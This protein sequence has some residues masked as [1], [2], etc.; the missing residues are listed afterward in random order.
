MLPMD[1]R[2]EVG[3]KGEQQAVEYLKKIGY[4]ILERNWRHH[5]GELDVVA[6][7]GKELVVVEVRTLE[8]PAF[9]LPEESVGPRKQRQLAKLGT[10]YVQHAKHEGD[11][12]VDV[13]AID[14]NGLRHLKNAVS[15]W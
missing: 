7:D 1:P 12:R 3:A 10:A 5:I 14:R 11:W 13:V 9:G 8:A 4:R 15:L 6:M 2:R